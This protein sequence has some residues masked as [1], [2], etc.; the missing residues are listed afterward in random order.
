MD[1]FETICSI[2]LSFNEYPITQPY[3]IFVDPPRKV[4]K[5]RR[6]SLY[7]VTFPHINAIIKILNEIQLSTQMRRCALL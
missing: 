6:H 2:N 7:L 1:K 5:E 3:W 4:N